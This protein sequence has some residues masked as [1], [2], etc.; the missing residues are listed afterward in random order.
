MTAFLYSGLAAR[1]FW[2]TAI[3]APRFLASA[4]ASGPA[5]LILL[6]LVV[7]RVSDFDPGA[8]GDPDAGR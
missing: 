8:A 5:L 6:A 1:P 3:M 4:F 2:L 7:R